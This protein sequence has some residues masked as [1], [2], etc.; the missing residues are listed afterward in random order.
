VASAI[1]TGAEH[2]MWSFP[3][4]KKW[5]ES[6]KQWSLPGQSSDPTDHEAVEP[7]AILP[8]TPVFPLSPKPATPAPGISPRRNPDPSVRTIEINPDESE[9]GRILQT[10]SGLRPQPTPRDGRSTA[11][12]VSSKQDPAK[13]TVDILGAMGFVGA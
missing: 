3:R 7:E 2:G 4:Y 9:F 5:L 1:E 12:S 13:I 11:P 8:R 10:P 6:A